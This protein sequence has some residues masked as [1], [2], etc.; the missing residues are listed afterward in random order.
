MKMSNNIIN[1]PE[2]E[3]HETDTSEK[4]IILLI[5][6]AVLLYIIYN[7][8]IK[9]SSNQQQS[10]PPSPPPPPPPYIHSGS[11][12]IRIDTYYNS[13]MQVTTIHSGTANLNISEM[14]VRNL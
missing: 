13:R 2:I 8:F 9:T 12:S 10:Q 14:F 7:T 3:T 5:L 1:Q 6:G 4:N 11:A